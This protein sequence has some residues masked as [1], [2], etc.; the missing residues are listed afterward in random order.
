MGNHREVA[1]RRVHAGGQ[2]DVPR[3]LTLEARLH[4]T[5]EANALMPELIPRALR[6]VSR[7]VAGIDPAELGVAKAVLAR[8]PGNLQ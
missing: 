3:G 2:E 6:A 5:E 4:L 8:V 1:E 7:A